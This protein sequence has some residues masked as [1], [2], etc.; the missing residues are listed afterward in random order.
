MGCREHF[1]TRILGF[2]SGLLAWHLL[3]PRTVLLLGICCTFPFPGAFFADV[4]GFFRPGA[5]C[6]LNRWVKLLSGGYILQAEEKRML[7]ATMVTPPLLRLVHMLGMALMSTAI[8]GRD[9]S[10]HHQ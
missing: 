6:R 4:M 9:L 8:L 2:V 5:E 10:K 1:E 7:Q 3:V